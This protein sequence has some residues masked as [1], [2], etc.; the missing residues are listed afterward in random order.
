MSETFTIHASGIGKG[1]VR[2]EALVSTEPVSFNNGVESPN[3][4]VVE[5][6]HQLAGLCVTGI[7]LVFPVGIVAA[8]VSYVLYDLS[9]R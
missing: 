1:L 2:A 7:V 5:P 3:G 6:D 4:I 9:H 8:G